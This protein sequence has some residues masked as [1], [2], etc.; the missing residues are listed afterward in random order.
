MCDSVRAELRG[1]SSEPG[2]GRAGQGRKKLRWWSSEQG[3]GRA[4]Q[5]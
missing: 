2:Q 5:S 3:Q 4:E 1:W